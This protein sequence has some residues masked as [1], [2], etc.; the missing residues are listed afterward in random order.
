MHVR[1][2]S[3]ARRSALGLFTALFM[4]LVGPSLASA[5][6]SVR[7]AWDPS[8]STDV[9]GYV[10]SYHSEDGAN[11]GMRNVGLASAAQVDDLRSGQ[12]YYFSVFAYTASGLRGFPST[13][14]SGIVDGPVDPPKSGE[15]PQQP[16]QL[17]YFAEGAT[18][19][20]DYKLALVNTGAAPSYVDVNFLREGGSPVYRRYEVP[21]RAHLTVQARD[22]SE[23]M[24]QA[25]SFG[26]VIGAAPGVVAERTMSWN[27]GG[28]GAGAHTA[29]AMSAPA[30]TWYLA[31]GAAGFWDTYILIANP[32]NY[33]ATVDVNFLRQ[34]GVS[35]PVRK[36]IA[37][38]ARLSIFT[39]EI[40][41]LQAYTF[42][43]QVQSDQPILVE[44]AMYFRF[45]PGEHWEGHAS[46]ASPAPSTTW[47]LA[48]GNTGGFFDTFVLLAN[49]NATPVDVT[50]RYL[51][52]EG[53]KKTETRKVA[54]HSRD[55]I[56]VDEIP[57]LAEQNVSFDIKSTGPITAERSMYWPGVPGPWYG[58]HNSSGVTSLGT[59]WALAEGELGGDGNA[60]TFVLLVN[61]GDTLAKVTVAFYRENG[62]PPVVV[63]IDVEPGVR[64]TISAGG[65]PGLTPGEHFGVHIVSTQ[66]IAVERSVYASPNG[67]FWKTGTNETGTKLK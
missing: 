6:G 48:E 51:T 43:A 34:D 32:N 36:S 64:K 56:K 15:T 18:G 3:S 67:I 46:S 33:Q 63:P 59:E 44:R 61:P 52:D 24:S 19:K 10:V 53:V 58:A 13:E 37:A 9:A 62:L 50:V 5:A 55:T 30:K 7:L 31:E 60:D 57:E 17:T 20:Y 27:G 28:F 45:S 1:A 42:G 49:P 11:V 40:P 25:W 21:A 54:G 35:V 41:E 66:P 65:T 2:Q 12:R 29:K 23:L 4:V 22:I 14:V 26:A 47:F 8:P 38:N 16:S 39:N